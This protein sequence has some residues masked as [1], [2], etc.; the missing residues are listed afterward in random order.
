MEEKEDKSEIEI[1][2]EELKELS[3]I[4]NKR[5]L[6]AKENI[7]SSFKINPITKKLLYDP[8]YE[9]MEKNK[10]RAALLHEIGHLHHHDKIIKYLLWLLI[11]FAIVSMIFMP[12]WLFLPYGFLMVMGSLMIIFSILLFY[13]RYSGKSEYNEIKADIF[14]ARKLKIHYLQ[15]KPSEILYETLK[16]VE[17]INDEGSGFRNY[18]NKI[19]GKKA[20]KSKEKRRERIK[21]CVDEKD[22]IDLIEDFK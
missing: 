18:L 1:V 14:A 10:L 15:L 19:T 13:R 2:F 3:L 16:E 4:E 8:K 21:E 12:Y 7:G 9:N 17:S 20:H 6:V 22:R 11:S 5:K